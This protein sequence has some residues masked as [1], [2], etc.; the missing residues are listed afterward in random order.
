[1]EFCHS[2]LVEELFR[3]GFCPGRTGF[4]LLTTKETKLPAENFSIKVSGLALTVCS[5]KFVR[6]V[7][8]G[9][10][11]KWQGLAARNMEFCHSEPVEEFLE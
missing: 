11:M 9:T 7:W 3:I 2:E 1:M 8:S 5:E 4:F 6:P 10:E